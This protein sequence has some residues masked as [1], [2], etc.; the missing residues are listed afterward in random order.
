MAV[1]AGPVVG[2][3]RAQGTREP[4][5]TDWIPDLVAQGGYAGLALLMFL[6]TVFPPVPSEVIMPFAGLEAARGT[7]SLL[8]AIL[9][10]TAGAML[11]NVLWY[12]AARACGVNRLLPLIDRHGAVLTLSRAEV[13]R[14]Q[15]ALLRRGALYVFVGRMIPVVRSVVSIPAGLLSMPRMPFIVWS[16]LGTFGWTS[17]LTGAGYLLGTRYSAVEHVLSPVAAGVMGV[18]FLLYLARLMRRRTP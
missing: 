12:A 6:E 11:G 15:A 10:G 2:V 16:S 5:L 3:L 9:A 18:A 1:D 13:E 14:G 4:Y 8:G 7:L 17:M